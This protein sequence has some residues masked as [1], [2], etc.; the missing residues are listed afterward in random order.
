[1]I[2]DRSKVEKE[3]AKGGI[4]IVDA[5][6]TTG[7]QFLRTCGF[8]IIEN[9][10]LVRV[11]VLPIGMAQVSSVNLV[12][13]LQGKTVKKYDEISHFELVARTVS[14][15]SNRRRGFLGFPIQ[16]PRLI[17][18]TVRSWPLLIQSRL[19]PL[20]DISIPQGCLSPL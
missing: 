12:K 7:N 3:Q 13:Y 16:S 14:C 6:D 5:P 10:M 19:F 9:D 1:M 17:S 18:F 11:A 15:C 8:I 2:R 20:R 4:H